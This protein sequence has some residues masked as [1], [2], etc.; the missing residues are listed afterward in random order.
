[1]QGL[2]VLELS[3]FKR[4]NGSKLGSFNETS[5]DVDVVQEMMLHSIDFENNVE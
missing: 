3:S 2:T 4:I 1:M 5:K